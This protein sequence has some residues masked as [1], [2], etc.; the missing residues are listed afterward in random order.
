MI[1]LELSD[2]SSFIFSW[3]QNCKELTVEIAY[4]GESREYHG[5]FDC[6]SPT[7]K[8]IKWHVREDIDSHIDWMTSLSSLI[9]IKRGPSTNY[10][11]INSHANREFR[12]RLLDDLLDQVLS[13]EQLPRSFIHRLWIQG[14]HFRSWNDSILSIAPFLKAFHAGNALL[15][16]F[17]DLEHVGDVEFSPPLVQL[18]KLKSAFGYFYDDSDPEEVIKYRI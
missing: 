18:S 5:R 4:E 1:E 7:E 6:F 12:S 2:L 15:D 14:F 3:C 8:K 9:V 11:N 16:S 13:T 17:R 10:S